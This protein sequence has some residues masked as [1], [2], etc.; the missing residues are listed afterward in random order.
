MK[1]VFNGVLI[2]AHQH[3]EHI[4]RNVETAIRR[5]GVRIVEPIH[6]TCA[7]RA[8]SIVEP[9]PTRARRI[10]VAVCTH[11]EYVACLKAGFDDVLPPKSVYLDDRVAQ[12]FGPG[13]VKAPL[14]GH[15]SNLEGKFLDVTERL[16]NEGGFAKKSAIMIELYGVD[17]KRTRRIT[18]VN[19][20]VHRKLPEEDAACLVTTVDGDFRFRRRT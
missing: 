15:L 6:F 3:A 2:E 5:L 4:G 14:R 19:H 16:S 7:W 10:L 1:T 11:A 9:P 18:M 17:Y 13:I 12:L 8:H 20:R